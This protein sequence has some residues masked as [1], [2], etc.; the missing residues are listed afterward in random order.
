MNLKH[1]ITNVIKE[2]QKDIKE[3]E[4]SKLE[5]DFTTLRTRVRE[6]LHHAYR[7][8]FE[9]Y[10]ELCK[11][12]S[13]DYRHIIVKNLINF[14]FLWMDFVKNFCERGR[15]L[16]PRWA[17]QGLEFLMVVCEPINTNHL[18]QEEFEEL[19]TSMDHCISHVVGS[20]SKRETSSERESKCNN[21]FTKF[22]SYNILYRYLYILFKLKLPLFLN[23]INKFTMTNFAKIFITF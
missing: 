2:F 18:T 23:D 17:N 22:L 3:L 19:K 15:G 8:G 9:Y 14:A 4:E 13:P 1:R 21:I 6:I 16:R 10:K 20:V 7:M 12:I 11:C 5:N